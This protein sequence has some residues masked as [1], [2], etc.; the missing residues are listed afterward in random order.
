MLLAEEF[1]LDTQGAGQWRLEGVGAD[2][3]LPQSILQASLQQAI[4][5]INFWQGLFSFEGMSRLKKENG[6]SFRNVST[7][8]KQ[9]LDTEFDICLPIFFLMK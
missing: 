6:D 8:I 7:M 5:L 3:F 9:I 4:L 1:F 2:V